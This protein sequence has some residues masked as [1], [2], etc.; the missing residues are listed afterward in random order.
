MARD[1]SSKEDAHSRLN[2]Q[3][4]ISQKVSYADIVIDNSGSKHELQ[5]HIDNLIRRLDKQAGWSWRLSWLLPPIGLLS[6]TW[7][8]MWRKI[9]RRGQDTY[10]VSRS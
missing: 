3:L 10:R 4:P 1:G 8:L 2:S 9:A 5:A 7:T 6:A